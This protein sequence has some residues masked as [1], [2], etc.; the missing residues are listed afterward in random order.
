MGRKKRARIDPAEIAARAEQL[1]AWAAVAQAN[2]VPLGLAAAGAG[3][4]VLS[5]YPKAGYHVGRGVGIVA[6]N[7]LRGLAGVVGGAYDEVKEEVAA[8]AEA[9][10]E[11]VLDNTAAGQVANLVP[12]GDPFKLDRFLFGPFAGAADNTFAGQAVNII[13]REPV[14]WRKFWLG[15]LG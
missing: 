6:E 4:A 12:G 7:V 14:N 15:P 3:F 1:K 9:F 11:R 8:A 10:D 13:E 5:V 2:K